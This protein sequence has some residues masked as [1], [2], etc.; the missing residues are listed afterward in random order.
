MS[1]DCVTI[2]AMDSKPPFFSDL[3]LLDWL[4]A[5]ALV[6]VVSL[7]VNFLLPSYGW[8]VGIVI[9]LALLFLAK[10]KRDRLKHPNNLG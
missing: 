9:A 5:A 7:L 10:R 1:G 4:L 8:A 2:R 6:V 3:S